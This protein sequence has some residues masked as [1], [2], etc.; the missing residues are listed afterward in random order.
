MNS[1][2][3]GMCI[4]FICYIVIAFVIGR[5]VKS[6]DDFYVAGRQ[7]PTGLIAGSMVASYAST[8]VFMGDAGFAYDGGFPLLMVPGMMQVT[9]YMMGAVLFGKYL[10]RSEVLTIPE[11]FGKRFCSKKLKKV[12]AAIAFITMLVYLLSIVQGIGTLMSVVTGID[13]NKCIILAVFVF[14]TITVMSG[15]SGVLIT[16]TIMAGLFTGTT[17]VSLLIISNKAGGWFD[18]LEILASN[19]E[20]SDLLAW[21]GRLGVL[22][23]TGAENI[24]WAFTYGIVWMS[25]C[26]VAPWQASRYMMARNEHTIIR[27]SFIAAIGICILVF[28]AGI[29]PV[30]IH[31]LNPQIEDSTHVLIWAAMNVLPTFIGVMLLAGILAAG[32]SSATT[33]LSL[34]GGVIANDLLEVK[35]EKAIIVGRWGMIIAALFVVLL[36]I[37]N[38]PSIFWILY[39]GGAIIASAWMP[40]I[41]GSVF[42][43]KLTK[44]GAL[45]GMIAGFVSCFVLKLY[46]AIVNVELPAY[47]DPALVGMVVNVLFMWIGALFSKIT[48][49][50]VAVR[51]KLFETPESEKDKMEIRKTFFYTKLSFGIGIMVIIMLL[52]FWA[53][54]YLIAK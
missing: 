2:F 27:S 54:P 26:M 40:V 7:A 32:I 12:S 43:K 19:P 14:S 10:R 13:Y 42:S 52:I 23:N 44:T 39:L 11:Y 38:S 30:M 47:L 15:A 53:I 34:I 37:S 49:E 4:S 31:I 16:D 25:V 8:G 6:I 18:A 5:N 22:Y 3:I 29:A 33:F 36:A 1:Y 24:L 9:G 21:S 35:E 20:T 51:E 46:T 41:I 45:S 50:E 48:N 17:V 28:T